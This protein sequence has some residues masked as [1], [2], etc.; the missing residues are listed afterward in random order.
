MNEV[1]TIE[2]EKYKVDKK[3]EITE[4]KL[5]QGNN[6]IVGKY[7]VTQIS[8]LAEKFSNAGDLVPREFQKQPEKCFVAI[9]KGASLGLDPFTALQRIAVVNGRATIWGDTALSLVRSSGKL[10]KF[11]EVVVEENGQLVAKCTV[12][13]TDDD[14]EHIEVFS[15]KDAVTANLWGKA[16]TWKTHPQRML[17]Y[18]AR[19]FALRD[20][21]PDILD[22]LHL[23]EEIEGETI[24]VIPSRQAPL[25]GKSKL[26]M[27]I[28]AEI[29]QEQEP[30]FQQVNN[31]R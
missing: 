13:R 30:L 18:K 3:A 4:R 15:Q 28:D 9:F 8:M 20:I 12:K 2:L 29:V 27:V 21:F 10:E 31:E 22:G 1:Q 17:K 24:D 5:E 16:G 25:Q 14:Y 11:E 19:A 23:K 26:D 6:L 7:N